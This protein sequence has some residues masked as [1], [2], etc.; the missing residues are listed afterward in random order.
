MELKTRTLSPSC[1]ASRH[2]TREQP[3]YHPLEPNPKYWA[4]LD[5]LAPAAA[6]RHQYF[7]GANLRP[8]VQITSQC[9]YWAFSA[10]QGN[11]STIILYNVHLGRTTLLVLPTQ[12]SADPRPSLPTEP[13]MQE[14]LQRLSRTTLA[15]DD[16]CV[17]ECEHIA[18]GKRTL[19]RCTHKLL[20]GSVCRFCHAR[21]ALRCSFPKKS[22][23]NSP[24]T[25]THAHTHTHPPTHTPTCYTGCGL[26]LTRC[27]RRRTRRLRPLV[28]RAA[29]ASFGVF[30]P[31]F[32]V[33][34]DVNIDA[35]GRVGH[36]FAPFQ[37]RNHLLVL[38]VPFAHVAD[39]KYRP[40]EISLLI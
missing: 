28:L 21:K 2:A 12:P 22:A 36:N 33:G 29:R 37:L 5:W 26:P 15:D 34:I 20:C 32:A 11:I 40:V 4:T 18:S 9:R 23:P 10:I 6:V 8:N 16:G 3:I 24:A 14:L 17:S 25:D 39:R 27:C 31:D 7:V 13:E 35:H 19:A 38:G 30:E 1:R